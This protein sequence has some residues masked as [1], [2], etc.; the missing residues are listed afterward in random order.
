MIE[1]FNKFKD[2]ALLAVLG[3][4]TKTAVDIK[5]KV[6]DLDKNTIIIEYRVSNLE[7][8]AKDTENKDKEQSK[9]IELIKSFILPDKIMLKNKDDKNEAQY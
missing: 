8:K 3:F 1:T 7:N 6:Y 2:Y 9:D 4:L 5:D